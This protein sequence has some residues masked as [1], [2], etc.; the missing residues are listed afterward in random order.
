MITSMT[1]FGTA[2][3]IINSAKLTVEIRSVNHRFFNLTLRLPG[4]LSRAEGEI[5]EFL[6]KKFSRGHITVVAW[7]DRDATPSLA[8]DESKISQYVDQLR[9]LK[10]KLQLA[11]EV[12]ISTVLR[13][14]GVV[15]GTS[16][17]DGAFES[18][19]EILPVVE[20]AALALT[21]MRSE[22]GERLE[23]ILSDRL[24]LIS[25][26][27]GRLEKRAPERLLEQKEQT[28]AA[29]SELAGGVAVDPQRLA[30]E[31]AILADKLDVTEELQ[32]FRVH[33]EAFMATLASAN[34]DG[35]GKRLGFLLQEM[36]RETNTTGSKAN[37]S[38][39][40]ADVVTLKEE[41]ERMREQVENIE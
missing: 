30:Q 31:V 11:G 38:A 14:P 40:L 27:V 19:G 3:G 39:M 7:V 4:A 21:K 17:E 18:V 10:Q 35:A 1:G 32:R 12:D 25:H 6:R 9:E 23:Q 28:K 13:L 33:I 36:L 41:L 5:R 20:Q 34:G 29:I 16:A 24:L 15:A 8:I 37:D 2:E 22:E 26:A